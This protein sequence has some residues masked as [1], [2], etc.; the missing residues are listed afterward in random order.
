MSDYQSYLEVKYKCCPEF[1]DEVAG[2][3]EIFTEQ[4]MFGFG[5]EE[6]KEKKYNYNNNY[7]SN[8]NKYRQVRLV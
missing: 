5:K 8:Y 4:K 3:I 6:K 2:W 7:N 1:R